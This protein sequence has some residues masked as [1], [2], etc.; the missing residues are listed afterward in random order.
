M[1]TCLTDLNVKY[2]IH[3]FKSPVRTGLF[4]GQSN[5]D[6]GYFTHFKSSADISG[7]L[8]LSYFS[9]PARAFLP[10]NFCPGRITET[11]FPRRKVQCGECESGKCGSVKRTS[12][13][14]PRVSHHACAL[15]AATNATR[16]CVILEVIGSMHKRSCNASS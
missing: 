13:P 12:G 11:L 3:F 9:R 1:Q 7:S 4:F 16:A 2:K 14:C 8:P 6:A 5:R 15:L 10:A